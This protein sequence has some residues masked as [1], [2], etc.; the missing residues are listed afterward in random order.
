[1]IS[2]LSPIYTMKNRCDMHRSKHCDRENP[3]GKL[4][5]R[6]IT[7]VEPGSTSVTACIATCDATCIATGKPRSQAGRWL[8]KHV[9]HTLHWT[10][11]NIVKIGHRYRM[12]QRFFIV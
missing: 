11:D 1:M 12:S 2:Q 7:R 9:F 8:T 10:C 3:G 4:S 6:L 5:Q